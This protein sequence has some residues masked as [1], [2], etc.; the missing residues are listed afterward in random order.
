[1]GLAFNNFILALALPTLINTQCLPPAT[2]A[3]PTS[4]TDP[5]T[6]S[7]TDAPPTP[8]YFGGKA[9]CPPNQCWDGGCET[10]PNICQIIC[11]EAC[12]T[13]CPDVQLEPAEMNADKCAALCIESRDKPDNDNP[14]RFWRYDRESGGQGVETKTCT[15]LSSD[16]CQFH[17]DCSGYCE[18]ED[19]GCPGENGETEAPKKACLAP[20]VYYPGSAWIHWACFNIDHDLGNP[21]NP[22]T[23]MHADTQCHTTTKCAD[24]DEEEAR[25]LKVRCDGNGDG[26]NGRWVPDQEVG[27]QANYDGVLLS[28]GDG[29]IAEHKC[30]GGADPT[31]LVVT[32][33]DM[34][35]GGELS[36]E[37]P[38]ADQDD[39]TFTI[40]APN[41]CVLLCDYHLAMVIEGRLNDEG[42]FK[43]YVTNVDPEVEIEQATVSEKIKCW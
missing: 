14:C 19:V 36:C 8:N 9:E 4:P 22:D 6:P 21:Y 26:E 33:A 35:I 1:M 5:P 40:T 34:G 38:D 23:V 3:Q 17:S 32:I 15:F 12:E 37:I 24:W 10:D 29:V 7:P 30:N 27:S 43:F 28:G 11:G 13:E 20:I 2:T 18:C 41:K 25:M 39:L 31:T 42:E 16:Q